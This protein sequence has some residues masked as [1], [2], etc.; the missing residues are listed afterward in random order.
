VSIVTTPR[1]KPKYA[2]PLIDTGA[3]LLYN[4]T[5][6]IVQE[7]TVWDSP[8][9]PNHIYFVNDSMS[10]MTAYIRHGTKDK[11]TFKK[12]IGFDRRGRTFTVLQSI[13][14][15]SESIKVAGSKGAV[16]NLT[17]ANGQWQCSCPGHTYRGTCKHLEM[18]PKD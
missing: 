7:T 2:K 1:L 12:P 5:M 15:E 18:A 3:F 11:F 8:S 6:K 17:R 9:A 13:D 16:Y 10:K 4:A 14:D